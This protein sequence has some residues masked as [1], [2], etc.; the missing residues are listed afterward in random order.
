M[1]ACDRPLESIDV[2]SADLVAF[3]EHAR[4]SL[5][6]E[7]YQ[8]LSAAIRTLGYA[9]ELEKQETTPRRS[10]VIVPCQHHFPGTARRSAAM[11]KLRSRLL[12]RGSG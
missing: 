6:E 10:R 3:L 5:S 8:E 7:A 1:Q 2:S 4:P 12:I 9:T 11:T